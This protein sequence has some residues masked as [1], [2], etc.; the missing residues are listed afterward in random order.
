MSTQQ[1]GAEECNSVGAQGQALVAH[2]NRATTLEGLPISR[3]LPIRDR[4]MVGPWC[5]LDRFGP[6]AFE[7]G[8]AM[9]VP[10]HPHIGLQTVSWLLEGEVLH[11]DSLGFQA[12][13]RPGGVNV[14]TAGRGIAHAEETPSANSGR[15]SGVQLWVA[16]P[17]DERRR[18]PGFTHVEQVPEVPQAGGTV[19][20]FAGSYEGMRSPARYFSDILGLDAEIRAGSGLALAL[21]L[22]RE[23]ALLLLEGDCLLAGDLV[24]EKGFL[25]YLGTQRSALEVHS[26]SGGRFLLIGGLPFPETLLM[27]WNFVAR[28]PEEIAEAR[29]DWEAGRGFGV[30]TGEHAPRLHAPD[31]VRFAR[32]NPA[33]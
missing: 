33:S 2:P 5:F 32:P 31:L 7:A 21:E 13:V 30:V 16:L 23:H 29:A 12:T 27:W 11:S 14:M 26:E 24:L 22:A 6:V 18:E 20:V 25:Y 3:A 8:R 4:R 10:P 17:E 19:Q 9:D 15:L 1:V 28:A